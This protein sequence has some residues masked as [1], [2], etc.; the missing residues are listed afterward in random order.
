[1]IE[2]DE[3]IDDCIDPSTIA[4]EI[5]DPDEIEETLDLAD[6]DIIIVFW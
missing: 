6:A 1:M 4:E 5:A 2:P 3:H